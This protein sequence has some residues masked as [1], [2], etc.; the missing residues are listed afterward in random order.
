MEA[1]GWGN[2]TRYLSGGAIDQWLA[3]STSAGINWYLTD[4]LGSITGVTDS[5]GNLL[6]STQYDSYGHILIQSNPIAADQLAFAGR[7]F[8]AESGLYYYRSRYYNPDLGRFLSE[9]S[10]G[11]ASG[12]FNISRFEANRPTGYIDPFGNSIT[13]EEFIDQEDVATEAILDCFGQIVKTD[14]QNVLAEAGVYLLL[15]ETPGGEGE[16]QAYVGST[17]RTFEVRVTEQI[18]SQIGG[19]DVKIVDMIF[20]PLSEAVAKDPDE[21]K[22][23]EQVVMNTFGKDAKVSGKL[24]NIR[25]AS[26]G[27]ICND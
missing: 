16:L 4:R 19:R 8:D 20:I 22:Q 9:D 17:T 7:E 10:I 23:V 15:G 11:F 1:V 24:L 6:N 13:E 25:N 18:R 2:V 14:V 12:D 3:R 21:V 27:V 5:N 26:L